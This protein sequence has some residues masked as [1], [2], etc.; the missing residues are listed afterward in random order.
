MFNPNLLFINDRKHDTQPC[1]SSS[2]VSLI[3]FVDNFEELLVALLPFEKLDDP[4]KRSEVDGALPVTVLKD[5]VIEALSS[6]ALPTIDP[7][8]FDP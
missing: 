7:F 5:P 4:R 6:T 8:K 2:A 3:C 1:T